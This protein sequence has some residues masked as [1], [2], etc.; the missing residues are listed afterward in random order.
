MNTNTLCAYHLTHVHTETCVYVYWTHT[1]TIMMSN[2]AAVISHTKI[3]SFVH[4]LAT[5]LAHGSTYPWY[6]YISPMNLPRAP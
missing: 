3:F 4:R 2:L 6:I 1:H 5:K